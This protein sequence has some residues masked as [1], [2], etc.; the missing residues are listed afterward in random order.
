MTA[1]LGLPKAITESAAAFIGA[2]SIP[3]DLGPPDTCTVRVVTSG[4]GMECDLTILHAGGRITCATARATAR[5]LGIS[6]IQMG[7]LLNF[8]NIK[9]RQC[10]L[11]L[12]K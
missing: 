11:G 6:T 2:E 10:E 4:E 1:V 3:I 9:V 5:R 12:F 7:K 8:F